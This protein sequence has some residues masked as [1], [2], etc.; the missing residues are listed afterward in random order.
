MARNFA[1]GDHMTLQAAAEVYNADLV[2]VSSLPD[3]A[4]KDAV[5]VVEPSKNVRHISV[6]VSLK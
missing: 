4:D 5:T 6:S 1:W 2:V 3:L